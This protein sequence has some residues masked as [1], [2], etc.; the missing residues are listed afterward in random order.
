MEKVAM[1]S[2]LKPEKN[3]LRSSTEQWTADDILCVVHEHVDT[4]VK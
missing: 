2:P 4:L 3:Q 1:K